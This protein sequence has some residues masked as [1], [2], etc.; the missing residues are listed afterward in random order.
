MSKKIVF[1]PLGKT[2]K[3][4]KFN[5]YIQFFPYNNDTKVSL[6]NKNVYLGE[7]TNNI[8][9]YVIQNYNKDR[10][11][12]KIKGVNTRELAVAFSKKK[13]FIKR[14][15]LPKISRDSY[16][17]V[18][19]IGCE[20]FE[21]NKLKVGVVHDVLNLPANEVL[22][23]KKENKEYLIPLID[24]VVKFIDINNKIIKIVILPGLL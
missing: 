6:D 19:L 1:V 20:V 18:D 8:K 23:V 9:K 15:D 16:Y 7:D 17:L 10:K 11:T 22:V 4:F 14:E 21:E 3:P 5:G 24:D 2:G 12:L 13:L